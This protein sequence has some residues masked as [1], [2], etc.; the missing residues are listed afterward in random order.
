MPNEEAFFP[1]Y[2]HP[3]P[4]YMDT[5]MAVRSSSVSSFRMDAHVPCAVSPGSTHAAASSCLHVVS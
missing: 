4:V 1:K 2:T 3:L 5:Y